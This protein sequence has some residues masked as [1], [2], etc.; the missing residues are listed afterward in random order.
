MLMTAQN[1]VE[2]ANALAPGIRER[3]VQTAKDRKPADESIQ[4]LIDSGIIGMLVPQ[5][6]GGPEVDF[7][8]MYDVIK[9]I[10]AACPSTGWITAFYV[11]HNTYIASFPEETQEEVYGKNGYVLLATASAPNLQ[12]EKVPG[13]WKISGRALWGSGIVH[14]DWV[15]LSGPAGDQQMNFLVPADEV[16]MLDTWHFAGMAGTGSNDYVAEDVFVPDNRAV[17]LL[18]FFAGTTEGAQIHDNDFYRIP[19]FIKAMCSILPVLTGALDG[20]YQA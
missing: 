18:D 6:W 15:T 20:A 9:P 12:A 1:F 7:T 11:V 13:G 3:A 5:K 8:A 4:E 17:P 2:K 10:S 14:A 19:F 16:K